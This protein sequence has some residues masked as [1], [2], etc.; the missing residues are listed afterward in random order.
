MPETYWDSYY[1]GEKPV[2]FGHH[3]IGD[4]SKIKNNTYGIDT[5]CCHGGY[6]TAI[7]LPG[8]IIHQVKAQKD[9]WKEEQ[10][11]WQIPVLKAKD[12][13]NMEISMINKQ[14]DKLAYIENQEIKAYLQSIRTWVDGLLLSIPVIKTRLDS[15]TRELMNTHQEEFTKEANTY[16]FK[17]FLFKSRAGNL[18][19]A[20]VEKTLYTPHK[21]M[22][23][24]KALGLQ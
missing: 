2:I 23:L 3:V 9:Y 11:V 17:T 13:G 24:A 8:F 16:F 22:E 10:I 4:V 18:T 12:W 1:T 6:L 7:E 20:D 5:G 15:F 14:L 21:I 19:V